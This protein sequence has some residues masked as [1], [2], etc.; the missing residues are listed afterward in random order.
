M[1]NLGR[2]TTYVIYEARMA[3]ITKDDYR[4]ILAGVARLFECPR[5]SDF[6]ELALTEILALVGAESGTFNYVAPAVP[7]VVAV[8]KPVLPDEPVRTQRFAHYLPQ[9]AVLYHFLST[10]DPGTFKL[11]DFQTEREYHAL[12]LYQEFYRELEY[13]DQLTF[14]LFPPGAEIVGIALARDRRSFTE[15]DREM[16]NLMRPYV[17]R[18][19]RHVERIGLLKRE[20]GESDQ[21]PSGARITGIVLDANDRPVQFGAE[22]QA[23]LGRFFAPSA[24]GRTR[25]PDP[26]RTLLRRCR[27]WPGN[28]TLAA[29]AGPRTLVQE[30]NGERLRITVM[31]RLRGSERTV[32]LSLE[33]VPGKALRGAVTGLT[34]RE[35]EV[36]LEVEKG[37][38][39]GEVSAAL[40]ISPLTVRVHLEHIFEKLKAPNRTAAVMAFRGLGAGRSD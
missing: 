8:A 30:G 20:L 27:T 34:K 31:P 37:K 6:P 36:L 10:G 4:A 3:A 24:S 2:Y 33:T 11:S 23:W 19:Y 16:L 28:G 15:R 35:I 1:A 14:M 12:P 7:Q 29:P 9:H 38:T 13:E 32:V 17:A 39:N 18:A 22:A 5:L 40:G 26:I 21:A 25:L